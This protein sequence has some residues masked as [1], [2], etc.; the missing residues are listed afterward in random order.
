MRLKKVVILAVFMVVL[1]GTNLV[2][3]YFTRESKETEQFSQVMEV[4]NILQEEYIEEVD[5]SELME[6]TVQGMLETLEDPQTYFLTREEKKEFDER[7]RGTFGGIGILITETD[8]H[9][10]VLEVFPGT[11]SEEAGLKEGDRI[12]K[13][14]Q[15][16]LSPVS[17]EEASDRLRGKK[18]TEVEVTIK[19]PGAEEPID[20]HLERDIIEVR[21]VESRWLE[22]GIASIGIS[23]FDKGTG[24]EFYEAL[25]E[26][27]EEGV[28]GL[29]LDLR[30]NRGG[31]L[32]QTVKVSQFIVPE[33][34]IVK[35]IG[36]DGEVKEVFESKSGVRPYPIAVL[37]NEGSASGAEILAG[38][39]QDHGVAELVG[40]TTFGKATVQNIYELDDGSGLSLTVA[41]YV[42][43]EGRDIHEEGLEPDHEVE[44]P[45]VFRYYEYFIP[46]RLEEG[47][48]GEAVYLLQEMLEKLGYEIIPTGK[49]DE[50]TSR[51]IKEFQSENNIS[52]TGA[53]DDLTWL[54]LRKELDRLME[55]EDP[56]LQ[57]AVEIINSGR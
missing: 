32:L 28:E 44:L 39:L 18:G 35:K 9:V 47:E 37:V 27:E 13:V 41:R 20:K 23:N 14:D 57:K 4:I 25:R 15:E 34:E 12:W 5:A 29:V 30:N 43:P 36:R 17:V 10:T 48:R 22:E 2:T 45:E 7:M 49:F 54:Q 6:G 8:R 46:E 50:N 51:V 19:R 31:S 53:F 3:F 1:A 24:D 21:T 26:K 56:Q 40:E 42:T 52:Q 38:A 33:G 55:E 16:E 11:P